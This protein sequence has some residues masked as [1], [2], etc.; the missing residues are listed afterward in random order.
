MD[1][2]F[3]CMCGEQL[4]L[5]RVNTNNIHVEFEI[6]PCPKCLEGAERDGFDEGFSEGQA[7]ARED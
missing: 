6:K 4:K 2:M 1:I 3:T 7:S 5:H